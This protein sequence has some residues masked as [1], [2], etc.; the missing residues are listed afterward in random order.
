M[1]EGT[2]RGATLTQA[3]IHD[4]SWAESGPLQRKIVENIFRTQLGLQRN[5]DGPHGEDAFARVVKTAPEL[6]GSGPNPE[7]GLARGALCPAVV[8]EMSVPPPGGEIIQPRDHAPLLARYYDFASEI[9]VRPRAA[10]VH[11]APE[12]AGRKTSPGGKA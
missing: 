9:M 3:E 4:S 1:W 11:M 2:F 6:Y 5:G 8:E 12:K 7:A 10:I